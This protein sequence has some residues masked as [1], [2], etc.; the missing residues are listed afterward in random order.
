MTYKSNIE[1]NFKTI[2]DCAFKVHKKLGPGLYG[3]VYEECLFYEIKR[4]GQLVEIQKNMLLNYE[5][6][7]LEAGYRVDLLV[8]NS[9]IV[10]TKAIECVN[11]IHMEQILTYMR[12]S[13]CSPGLLLNFNVKYLKDGIRR[14]IT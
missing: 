6:I 12:L 7:K 9:I 2:L 5:N 13:K 4:T 8:E 10:E 1:N 3:N 11:N 14:V